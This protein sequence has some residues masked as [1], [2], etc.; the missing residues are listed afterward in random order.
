[1][2]TIIYGLAIVGALSLLVIS[3][4]ITHGV[5]CELRHQWAIEQWTRGLRPDGAAL[6]D[7]SYRQAIQEAERRG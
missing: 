3:G 2:T 6:Y 5:V 4:S 1:M 7:R